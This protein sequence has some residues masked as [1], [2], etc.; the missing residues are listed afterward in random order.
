M[1]DYYPFL[2]EHSIEFKRFS[3][4]YLSDL[5]NQ[6][7]I[8]SIST[9]VVTVAD[10][11]HLQHNLIEDKVY[12]LRNGQTLDDRQLEIPKFELKPAAAEQ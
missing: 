3:R 1:V 5:K 10:G 6:A 4:R 11:Y 8:E 7:H 12:C 9:R 2:I